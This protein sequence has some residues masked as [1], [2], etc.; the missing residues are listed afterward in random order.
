MLQEVRMSWRRFQARRSMR[1]SRSSSKTAQTT[2]ARFHAGWNSF[3]RVDSE[4][5]F[6][7]SICNGIRFPTTPNHNNMIAVHVVVSFG[8]RGDSVW[9]QPSMQNNNSR[10]APSMISNRSFQKSDSLRYCTASK[11]PES[12]NRFAACFFCRPL[13]I[14]RDMMIVC[15]ID[16]I[17]LPRRKLKYRLNPCT[18]WIILTRSYKRG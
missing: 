3:D 10:M 9:N 16:H 7:E 13:S 17:V 14:L 6:A 8:S 2:I 18:H 1:H 4:W 5:V 15:L 12:E 11:L